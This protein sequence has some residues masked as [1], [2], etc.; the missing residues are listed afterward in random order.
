MIDQLLANP[1][2][3]VSV[4]AGFYIIAVC[5]QRKF[6][7]PLLNPLLVSIVMIIGLLCITGISYETYE[8][9]SKFISIFVTPATVSLGIMLEKSFIHLKKYYKD[10]LIGIFLG[11]LFHTC[12]LFLFGLLFHFD[13]E[14]MATLFPK[15]ITTAIAVDV[16]DSIGGLVSFTVTI[17]VF[18]GVVGSVIA[19][20]IFKIGKITDPVAQGVA[21]GS[22]SHA[23]GTTKAI[24]IGE[25]QGAMSGVSIVVT[26]LMVVVL[27]P[28]VKPLIHL[29]FP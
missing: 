11:I 16:S 2:L 20:Y 24:E 9:G 21:L 4:T 8:G 12:M 15:S 7:S 13:A 5:L 10:I 23:V 6:K 17:V 29:L 19:P 25:I 14:M 18:T 26:G 27:A 3:W 22:S 1:Y 28:I